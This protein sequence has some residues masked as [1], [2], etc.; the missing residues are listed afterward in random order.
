MTL[1][2]LTYSELSMLPTFDER[3]NYLKLVGVIGEDTFGFDRYLNQ[4]F[5]NSVEWK[6]A[7]DYV[8]T[9]DM[10]CDL[11]IPGREINDKIYVHHMNPMSIKDIVDGDSHIINPEFLITVSFDTHNAIHYG[12]ERLLHR[13]D[14]IV[15]NQNDTC[16]WKGVN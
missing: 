13:K 3:Y 10:G 6:R 14:L 16:P 9:R 15:R 1:K 5:Y 4:R 11:G 2:T 12:D 8:I 7:R